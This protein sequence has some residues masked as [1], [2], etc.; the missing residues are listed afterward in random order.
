MARIELE[1][2]CLNYSVPKPGTSSILSR[3]R[4]LSWGQEMIHVEALKQVNLQI[5]DG[6]RVGIIGRNG[7]GKSTMLRV[8][9]DIFE[10]TSGVR[11]VA[12]RISSIFEISL[13]F[14]MD[15]TGWEN[16]NFR[17]F[18]QGETRHRLRK[19][20][21]EI[22]AFSELK[23]HL[24]MPVRYYSSGMKV[25]LAFAIATSI[26]PD[27]LLVDEAFSAGDAGFR[28][29]A[30]DRIN[31]LL[32]RARIVVAVSHEPEILTKMCNRILWLQEGRIRQDGSPDEVL[33]DYRSEFM[34]VMLSPAMAA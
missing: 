34:N 10:P 26:D 19:K 30:Q 6:E 18:L 29:K 9:A 27:I 25:R 21:M 16:I 32:S 13:G 5:G 28:H 2:V 23:E 24:D 20:M 3:L 33:A 14:E 8:L 17:C 1:N 15:A 7:A 4:R 11:R 31:S 22:A 12:G